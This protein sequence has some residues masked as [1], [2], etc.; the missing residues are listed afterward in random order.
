MII[1]IITITIIT[2]SPFESTDSRMFAQGQE[3]ELE[4]SLDW[5]EK[6]LKLLSK[7]ELVGMYSHARTRTHTSPTLAR[8]H[9]SKHARTHTPLFIH[10]HAQKSGQ[11]QQLD[12]HSHILRCCVF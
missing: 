5:A 7:L 2:L 6:M 10:N 4:D 1:T 11:V 3:P 8:K 12:A 9:A